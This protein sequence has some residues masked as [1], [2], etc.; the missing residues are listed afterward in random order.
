MVDKDID[1]RNLFSD[2]LHHEHCLAYKD[3]SVCSSIPELERIEKSI[4]IAV[5]ATPTWEHYWSTLQLYAYTT[6]KIIF[7]EKPIAESLAEARYMT[8]ICSS[9]GIKLAINHT[10]RWDS[11]YTSV[12]PFLKTIEPQYVI[13]NYP[14]PVLRDGTHVFDVLHLW[15]GNVK[16]VVATSRNEKNWMTE[17]HPDSKFSDYN[18]SG[19]LKF[20]NGV[21]AFYNGDADIDYLLFEVDVIGKKGRLTIK[22]NGSKV[23][24]STVSESLKYSGIK[25]LNPIRDIEPIHMSPLHSSTLDLLE[26]CTNIS[27]TPKCT[28]EDGY[29]ALEIAIALDKSYI[30]GTATEEAVDKGFRI[31]YTVDLPIQTDDPFFQAKIHSW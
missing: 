19:I 15:F 2:W 17:K 13:F 28:A 16:S 30:L 6:P 9:K 23:E 18:Y 26:A 5:I 25:E 3:I 8:S 10:R 21:T 14:G 20:W 12:I 7:L 29:K 4:D 31:G 24:L 22:N 11:T 27:Y 1:Q